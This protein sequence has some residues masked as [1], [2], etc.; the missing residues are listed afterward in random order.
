MRDKIK[1]E[2]YLEE[3]FEFYF[4]KYNK[5]FE[6]IES[7]VKYFETG[8]DGEVLRE[9]SKIDIEKILKN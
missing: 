8:R 7:N 4:K 2:K 6:T 3:N 9:L 1:D 5:D